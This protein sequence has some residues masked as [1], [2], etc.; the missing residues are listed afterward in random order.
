[1]QEQTIFDIMYQKFKID[2][3]IRLIELFGGYGSQALALKYLGVKFEHWKLVEWAVKSIQAYKDIHFSN[4]H[5]NYRKN[6]E[7]TK[8]QLIEWLYNYGISMNYNEQMTKQQIQRLN[9]KQ[10]ETIYNNIF[11]TNNLVNI[12]KAK[13]NGFRFNVSDGNVIAKTITTNAGSR[14]DDN[15]IKTCLLKNKGT[16]ISRLTNEA[17][18]LMAR[19]YKGF[20]NQEMN[21]VI[22]IKNNNSKGYLV[23]CEKDVTVNEPKIIDD[24]DIEVNG[25]RI[26]NNC[27]TQRASRSGLKIL[28]N[29]LRIR[30][31]T[32]KECFRLMG[33]KDEDFEKC[34]KNQSDSSLYHLAGDSIVVNV[35]MAIFKEML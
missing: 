1:M 26:T 29:D 2:K 24:R 18:T 28:Q 30:K 6:V 21:A 27:P 32:S 5:F 17:N 33:V 3:P 4:N 22:Q 7:A 10:L 8:E 11:A 35:L 16:K 23:A 19:D 13:G 20:G 31:L 15:Y 14:M 25:I 12:Q 9:E 34:K